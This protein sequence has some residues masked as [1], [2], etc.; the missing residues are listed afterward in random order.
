MVRQN[1]HYQ[2]QIM[3]KLHTE[4]V[5]FWIL[6]WYPGF[7]LLDCEQERNYYPLQG[8]RTFKAPGKIKIQI[9][10]SQSKNMVIK[11]KIKKA[12]FTLNS[13]QLQSS[14]WNIAKQNT[15]T[16]RNSRPDLSPANSSRL[17]FNDTHSWSSSMA[18]TFRFSHAEPYMVKLRAP[19]QGPANMWDLFVFLLQLRP[20][21]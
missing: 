16:E 15:K 10:N 2:E 13:A 3:K 4:P 5:T 7:D 9:P 17:C 12:T 20:S 14:R 1:Q 18:G 6:W 19:A 11:I 8:T 21:V